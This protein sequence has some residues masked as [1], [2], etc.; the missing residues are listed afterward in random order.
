MKEKHPCCTTL[1]IFRCTIKYFSWSLLLFEW[2]TTSFLKAKLL[3]R[4]PFLKLFYTINISQQQNHA[5]QIKVTS[6]NYNELYCIYNWYPA[7][8]LLSRVCLSNIFCLRRTMKLGFLEY[9]CRHVDFLIEMP[10]IEEKLPD[11]CTRTKYM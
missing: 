11:P 2:E 4:E 6:R 5:Y 1:L 7:I 9:S 8:V 3:Q 10:F